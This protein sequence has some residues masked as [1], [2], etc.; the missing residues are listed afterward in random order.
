MKLTLRSIGGVTGPAGAVRYAL[1]S[2][3]LSG[4]LRAEAEH[5]VGEA[6]VFERPPKMLLQ[7]PRPSDFRYLLE[8][9]DGPRSHRVELHLGAVD[10]AL[11]ALVDWIEEHVEP[12]A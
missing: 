11:R 10:D 4:E 6:R 2:E 8:L 12:N 9:Q 1:D 7:R 3:A 5:L